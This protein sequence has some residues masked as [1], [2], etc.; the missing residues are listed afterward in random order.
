MYLFLSGRMDAFYFKEIIGFMVKKKKKYIYIYIYIYINYLFIFIYT[1]CFF[2]FSKVHK[3]VFF[4]FFHL[5]GDS[6]LKLI[7]FL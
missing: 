7:S 1:R 4:F 6:N 5:K 3:S 2:V